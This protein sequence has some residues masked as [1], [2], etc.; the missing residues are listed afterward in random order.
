MVDGKGRAAFDE[1]IRLNE[2]DEIT[3]ACM[4]NIFWIIDDRI[5]TPSLE[6][7]CLKGTTREFVLENLECLEVKENVKVL[8]RADAIFLTSAG[9]G[10]AEIAE[11]DGCKLGTVPLEIKNLIPQKNTKPRE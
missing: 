1:A 5:Y 4:A 7:G 2:K 3:A 10:I 8:E 9:I 11:I 6:T